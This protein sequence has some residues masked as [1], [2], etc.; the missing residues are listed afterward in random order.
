MVTLLSF[1]FNDDFKLFPPQ[2]TQLCVRIN[3][4][5]LV[6]NTILPI[7]SR[8]FFRISQKNGSQAT[9]SQNQKNNANYRRTQRSSQLTYP[10]RLPLVSSLLCLTSHSTRMD[11][12]T[13]QKQPVKT[14]EK[15]YTVWDNNKNHTELCPCNTN[16]SIRIIPRNSVDYRIPAL[17]SRRFSW[18]QQSNPAGTCDEKRDSLP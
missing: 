18:T 9:A 2:R 3:N 6:F 13:H 14:H 4:T 15:Q 17:T 16:S 12:R 7:L 11:D 8:L 5:S 10:F 1:W